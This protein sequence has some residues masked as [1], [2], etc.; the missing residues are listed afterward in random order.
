[1]IRSA[2]KTVI[3]GNNELSWMNPWTLFTNLALV[4]GS[5]RYDLPPLAAAVQKVG[6]C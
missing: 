6:L 4:G 5:S 2:E 3:A 1:V